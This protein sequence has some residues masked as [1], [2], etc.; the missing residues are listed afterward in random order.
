MGP[1]G[2][3]LGNWWGWGGGGRRNPPMEKYPFH[4]SRNTPSIF[5]LEIRN[6]DTLRPD[7][8]LGSYADFT[9]SSTYL[10]TTTVKLCKINQ[11]IYFTYLSSSISVFAAY[12]RVE[13]TGQIPV[14]E[15]RSPVFSRSQPC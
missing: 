9:F 5:I 1:M 12:W 3:M 15:I 2:F 10:R 8:P 7:R 14:V 4:G 11:D 13:P 6:Q